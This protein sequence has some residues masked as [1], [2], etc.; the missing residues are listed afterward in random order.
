MTNSFAELAA[1]LPRALSLP[2]VETDPGIRYVDVANDWFVDPPL[3][4]DAEY[5]AAAGLVLV[6]ASAAVGK[7]TAAEELAHRTG[8]PLW[9]LSQVQVGSN[10]LAGSVI[11]AFG[12]VNGPE[13][14]RGIA[15]GTRGLILDALDE[16]EVRAGAQNFEAFVGDLV[17]LARVEREKPTLVLLAR[18]ETA[19][20]IALFL[21]MAHVPFARVQLDYFDERG[22]REFVGKRLSA[23]AQRDERLPVHEQHPQAF[24]DALS[25]VFKFVQRTLDSDPKDGWNDPRVAT[26][27]GYAP[28]LEAVARYVEVENFEQFRVE[29]AARPI[30][31]DSPDKAW[32]FLT[33][34]INDLLAREQSK[35]SRAVQPQVQAAADAADWTG[36]S[37]L[38]GPAE[39]VARILH[40]RMP[41]VVLHA[42]PEL[43]S[44]VRVAYDEALKTFVP[45]HPFLGSTSGFAN[46]VFEEFTYAMALVSTNNS[47]RNAVRD[48]LHRRRYLPTPLLGRFMLVLS[49]DAGHSHVSASN[50]GFLYDSLTSS[51]D[52]FGHP[53]LWLAQPSEK[54]AV[55]AVQLRPRDHST[56]F[57]SVTDVDEAPISF[58]RR[59]AHAIIQV[60]CQVILGSG[61]ESVT[62]GPNVVVD[63]GRI[64][65]AAPSVRLI[66]E[67]GDVDVTAKEFEA[68]GPAPSIRIFGEATGVQFDWQPM[69]YPWIEYR[70]GEREA[71]PG[72]VAE[73]FDMLAKILKW[74]R[75]HG[76]AQLG[77][78]KELI[79]NVAVGRDTGR[80]TARRQEMLNFLI[81]RG[82]V[83]DRGGIYELDADRMNQVGIN[84][85]DIRSRTISD[86]VEQFLRDFHPQTDEHGSGRS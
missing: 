41:S 44:R 29:L 85:A 46:V 71:E 62:L 61:E 38:F 15:D 68:L 31:G 67:D 72:D 26:F 12:L 86:S 36:W 16:A 45:Q 75:G 30:A 3:A 2:I 84:W 53:F 79:D 39:Q 13:V 65:I 17:E 66:T 14:L 77:R 50:F 81:N 60:D 54:V 51:I 56:I 6:G 58:W 73:A 4:P 28:V 18:N 23:W 49:T 27:L 5:P 1:L 59:L 74:F 70:R 69:Y 64:A 52:R 34:V 80:R 57:F 48:E 83:V 25:E 11:Q 63:A 82:V 32:S 19:E 43:P 24:Q 47:V 10:T 33:Q 55:G 9:D 22:A 37:E 40:F 21:E 8:L 20:L 35:V 7:S 78:S 42:V 76:H